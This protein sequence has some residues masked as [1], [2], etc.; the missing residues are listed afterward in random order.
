MVEI[1][2][3]VSLEILKEFTDYTLESV[4]I[5]SLAKRMGRSHVTLL[6]H[7]E[8]LEH[9]QVLQVKSKGRNKELRLNQNSI[10]TKYFLEIA[11]NLKLVDA[12]Q[13]QPIIKKLCEAVIDTKE[14]IVLFG[15]FAKGTATKE[16]D[17]D[18]AVSKEIDLENFSQVYGRDVNTK[19][20]NFHD[21]DDHLTYEILKN[22]V[23]IS[24][25][26]KF[27]SEVLYG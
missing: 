19:K 18:L 23:V 27:V 14:T 25:C 8:K 20:V 3:K 1:P 10:E 11:E 2:T 5:S 21:K 6:P 13:E 4:T 15:S 22:H 9:L 7:I 12:I 16:S 17:I 24:G 26:S